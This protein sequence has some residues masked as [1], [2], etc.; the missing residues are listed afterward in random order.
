M[1]FLTR[2]QLIFVFLV[3]FLVDVTF[4]VRESHHRMVSGMTFISLAVVMVDMWV[5]YNLSRITADEKPD[6]NYRVKD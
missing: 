6:P 2:Q 4:L 1:A 5:L 3:M